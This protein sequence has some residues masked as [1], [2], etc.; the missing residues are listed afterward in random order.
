[1][2]E[3][4]GCRGG[5]SGS[6]RSTSPMRLPRASNHPPLPMCNRHRRHRRSNRCRRHRRLHRHHCCCCHRRLHRR[7][8][9]AHLD[10]PV[11]KGPRD[12]QVLVQEGDVAEQRV[13]LTM[14]I[15][16]A[17]PTPTPTKTPTPNPNLTPAI[18]PRMRAYQPW[19]T[20]G[21]SGRS[22][23]RRRRVEGWGWDWKS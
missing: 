16:Q 22:R 12:R 5:R 14:G 1:M 8:R 9:P 7:H 21:G 3:R 10:P 6:S 11:P 17:P 20:K 13:P 23:Q 18:C 4:R 19:E 15:P 2:R